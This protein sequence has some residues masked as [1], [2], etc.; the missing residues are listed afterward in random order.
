MDIN[1]T[2]CG[3]HFTIYINQTIMLYNLNFYS[4]L[5]INLNHY[6][7]GEKF[8]HK[9]RFLQG[10]DIMWFMYLIKIREQNPYSVCH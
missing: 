3:H 9:N 8:K 7:T 1:E 10:S 6:K 2:Y 5:L 4:A